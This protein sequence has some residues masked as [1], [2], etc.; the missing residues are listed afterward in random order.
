MIEIGPVEL[1]YP[2]TAGTEFDWQE[3]IQDLRD[4]LGSELWS[5][6][7]LAALAPLPDLSVSECADRH[8][9]LQAGIS[10]SPGPWRT[11][12]T[13]YLQLPMDLFGHPAVR[14]LNLMFSTQLG[15][16]ESIYNMLLYTIA[17]NPYP[18]LMMYSRED[19][20]KTISRT[21]VQPMVEDCEI[22]RAKKPGRADLYQLLEMHFAGMP[23]Y[24]VGANS[25]SALSQKPCCIIIRD[26]VD[27]YLNIGMA[28]SRSAERAKSF[29]DIRKEVNV[30]SPSDEGVGIH[31]LITESHLLY[32]LHHPCPHCRELFVMQDEQLRWDGH[33]SGH[34]DIP[35]AKKSAFL[36]CP[37]CGA[38]ITDKERPWMISHHRWIPDRELDELPE[39][40][41]FKASSFTSPILTF[42]D[43]VE[44]RLNAE[45]ARDEEGTIEP[46]KTYRND[47]LNIPWKDTVATA[48]EAAILA[49]AQSPLCLP[50]LVAPQDAMALT[51]GIDPQKHG[52][53][54]V[55]KAW[56]SKMWSWTIHYGFLETWADVEHLVFETSFAVQGLPDR[57]MM[58][59]RAA[60]DIGGGA[61]SVYGDDWSKTEEIVTWL[62]ANGRGV[63]HGVKGMSREDGPKVKH[64]VRD[65]MPGARGGIIPGGMSEWHLAPNAFKDL[66]FWRLGNTD[67]DPQPMFLHTETEVSYARQI[68]AEEKI[69]DKNGRMVYVRK[70]KDNHYLDCE[71]YATACADFQWMGGVKVL[72]APIYSDVAR[73]RTSDQDRPERTRRT[74]REEAQYLGPAAMVRNFQR[75]AWLHN[76]RR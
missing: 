46:L 30:S 31:K 1:E 23:L 63:V 35:A 50:P 62:R 7:E 19:D 71:Y 60:M 67:A 28:L 41:G 48:S 11:S 16:T 6:A 34:G 22:L 29:W 57:R 54:F 36:V 70:H 17:Y 42:G 13:P 39:N 33:P 68:M 49:R 76:R 61:D 56:N 18:T 72:S 4:E 32:T 52:F 37:R 3:R 51:C 59:W 75:P 69:R 55:V 20:A 47:W 73:Q 25:L 24:I 10:R 74:D 27:K 14:V 40:V 45:K 5:T 66:F 38:V 43:F 2:E 65:K 21:R 44:Q 53:W 15:K 9:I 64:R 8:R 58:I 26:E 12:Y